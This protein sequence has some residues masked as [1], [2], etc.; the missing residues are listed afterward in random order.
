MH[1]YVEQ[2]KAKLILNKLNSYTPNI[3]FTFKDQ[4]ALHD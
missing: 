3:N 1:A 2:T 4:N